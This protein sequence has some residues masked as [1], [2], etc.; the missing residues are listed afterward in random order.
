MYQKGP[1]KKG[2]RGDT[3]NLSAELQKVYNEGRRAGLNEAYNIVSELHGFE[4]K[5]LNLAELTLTKTLEKIYLPS[6]TQI[7]SHRYVANLKG[8]LAKVQ[9][10]KEALRNMG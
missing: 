3:M 1:V 9:I 2:L 6:T 5:K 7:R 8:V 10:Q 4:Q